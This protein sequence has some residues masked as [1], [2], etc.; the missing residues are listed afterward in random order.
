MKLV[1]EQQHID[2]H[3]DGLEEDDP[4]DDDDDNDDNDYDD[5][6]Y[7]SNDDGEL[8]FDYGQNEQQQDVSTAQNSM[9]VAKLDCST[10]SLEILT[11]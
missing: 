9:E 6:S 7:D 8:S 3:F 4:Y 2:Y 10:F 1:S 5:D 11:A